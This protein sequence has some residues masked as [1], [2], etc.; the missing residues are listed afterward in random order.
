[1]LGLQVA[2]LT[3]RQSAVRRDGEGGH[4]IETRKDNLDVSQKLVN[5]TEKRCFMD[6]RKLV[7]II[8]D[9][10]STGISLHAEKQERNQRRRYHITLELPWSADKAIQQF[11][12]SHR[13]NQ[14]SA[15]V[16]CLLVADVGGEYRFASAVARRLQTLGALLKGDR[17][18]VGAG[19]DLRA[20]DVNNVH[21]IRALKQ[22]YSVI[23]GELAKPQAAVVPLLPPELLPEYLDEGDKSGVQQEHAFYLH[24]RKVRFVLVMNV[25]WHR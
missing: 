11:G 7:A 13:S 5:M 23:T 14:S 2:E 20:F 18:A 15:P 3:G 25:A 6:G 22:M 10:A 24:M 4:V 9:A 21:G 16:Y 17:R 1:M 12:R 8:S 19:Q